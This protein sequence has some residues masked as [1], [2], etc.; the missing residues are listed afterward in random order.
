MI[1]MLSPDFLLRA[2]TLAAPELLI[3]H[4]MRLSLRFA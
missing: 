3:F 2:D 4:A 1:L